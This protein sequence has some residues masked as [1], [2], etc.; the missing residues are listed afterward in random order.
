L[1]DSCGG[2]LSSRESDIISD[3]AEHLQRFRRRL[4][5]E[6]LFRIA[7]SAVAATIAWEI[8]LQIPSLSPPFFAPIAAVIGL[9]ADRGRR[10][11]QAIDMIVGVVAGI[12]IGAALIE[13]AG[14]GGWQLG[15][16]TAVALVLTT[17]AGVRPIIRTQAAASVILVVA[18]H[19]PGSNL[20]WQ[21]LIDA[22]IGGGIAIVMARFLFPVDPL[23]L[24]RHEAAELREQLAR[25]LD[26]GAAAIEKK[27]REAAKRVLTRLDELDDRRLED[28]LALAREVVRNAPRRRP[29]RR[30]LDALGTSWSELD[31]SVGDARAVGTGVVRLVSRDEPPPA[32]AAPALEAGAAAVRAID[33]E[34]ARKR[35][36]VA[37]TCARRLLEEDDSIASNVIA[38]GIAGIA[39]HARNAADAREEDRR[40]HQQMQKL[41]IRLPRPSVVSSDDGNRR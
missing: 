22:L 40:L 4:D 21:R 9:A 25:A 13:I 37:R 2:G 10:G 32:A 7:Q 28:A 1:L 29:L 14:A 27:D 33:P 35:A 20:A 41:R 3:I 38:H 18:L 8:A 31:R 15:V 11:R 12:L 19:V 30:R 16:G 6:T 36:E 39:D 26:A 17:A 34:E 5:R 23:E 24:V